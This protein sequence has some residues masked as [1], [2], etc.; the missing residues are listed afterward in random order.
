VIAGIGLLNRSLPAVL[1]LGI[2]VGLVVVPTARSQLRSP[3]LWA[4]GLAALAIWSPYLL[5][6]ATHGWPQLTTSREI[7]AE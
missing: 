4:G 5:R 6:Q 2:A 3:W 7:R 1:I